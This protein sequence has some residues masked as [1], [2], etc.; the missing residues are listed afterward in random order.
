VTKRLKIGLT[1]ATFVGATI[2]VL[3]NFTEVCRLEAVTLNG[4]PVEK[5]SEEFPVLQPTSVARQSL[6]SVARAALADDDVYKV[7]VDI[8]GLHSLSIR[9][10]EFTPECFLL[11]RKSGGLY[12]LDER[13]RVLP[14]DNATVDWERPILTGLTVGTMFQRCR[15]AGVHT[16]LREL[17]ELRDD[18]EDLYRLIEEIHFEYDGSLTTQIAGLRYRLRMTP[19]RFQR[20]IDQYLTFVTRFETDLE[21]VVQLDV[22]FDNMVTTRGGK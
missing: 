18:N 11:D 21:G 16:V 12:G 17:R 5:W 8:S 7:D 2:V 4:T 19:E 9:T 13:A 22:R 10:N 1:I 3:V 14:L 6:D 20:G 15:E